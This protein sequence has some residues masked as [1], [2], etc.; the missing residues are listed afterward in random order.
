MERVL[1]AGART[2]RGQRLSPPAGILYL[3]TACMRAACSALS[4]LC[5]RFDLLF[6]NTPSIDWESEHD[7]A[8]GA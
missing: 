8:T 7:P 2:A 1:V 3:F 5:A 6:T 4:N